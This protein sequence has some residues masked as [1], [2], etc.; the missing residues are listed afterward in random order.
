VHVLVFINYC[1]LKYLKTPTLG[2]G[3]W[4]NYTNETFNTHFYLDAP[5]TATF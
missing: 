3:V 1:I 5:S 4:R 2:F